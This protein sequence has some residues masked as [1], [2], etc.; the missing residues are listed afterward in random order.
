MLRSDAI[1]VFILANGFR[2]LRRRS[3]CKAIRGGEVMTVI[4]THFRVEMIQGAFGLASGQ[5]GGSDF[6]HG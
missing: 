4:K 3:A 1:L 5:D 6:F 2:L